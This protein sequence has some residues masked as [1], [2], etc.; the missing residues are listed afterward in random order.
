[1]E[2]RIETWIEAKGFGFITAHDG[3]SYF[4]HISAIEGYTGRD[5]T[6][7]PRRGAQVLF[8]CPTLAEERAH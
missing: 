5:T 2:G 7:P 8:D 3:K 4:A 1:M 6:E